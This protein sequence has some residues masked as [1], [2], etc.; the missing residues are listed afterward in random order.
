V[1]PVPYPAQTITIRRCDGLRLEGDIHRK[2]PDIDNTTTKIKAKTS[3]FVPFEMP[4]FSGQ[5]ET[6][7]LGRGEQAHVL[8]NFDGQQGGV[9]AQALQ[10]CYGLD[11]LEAKGIGAKCAAAMG[12]NC[13]DDYSKLYPSRMFLDV[14]MGELM[15]P[16]LT[17]S[18]AGMYV[19]MQY[20]HTHTNTLTHTHTHTHTHTQ[21]WS[22][23]M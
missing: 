23:L 19:C 12:N 11:I 10:S 20:A 2:R 22:E 3:I 14:E 1:L 7:E 16:L 21:S 4:A 13:Q 8:R 18:M 17:A 15:R 9:L 6:I 5:H